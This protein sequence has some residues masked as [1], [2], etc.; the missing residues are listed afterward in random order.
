MAIATGWTPETYDASRRRM[1]PCFD[2][3]YG[4]AAELVARTFTAASRH[5]RPR[6]LDLGAG[7]GILAAHVAA[8]VPP[9]ALTLLDGAPDMLAK[10]GERLATHHPALVVADIPGPTAASTACSTCR[11]VRAH[12]KIFAVTA[13]PLLSRIFH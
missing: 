4:A 10:A 5:S 9:S 1:V 3:F 8:R 12:L 11:G 2:A 13:W 6:M 7:T